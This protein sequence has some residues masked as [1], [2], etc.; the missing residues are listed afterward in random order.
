[1]NCS[2]GVRNTV[3]SSGHRCRDMFA[4]WNSNSKSRHGAQ[5]AHDDRQTVLAREI[6]GEA[7]VALDLDVRNIGQHPPREPDALLE[8]EHRR[9]A[10]VRRDGDDDAVEHAGGAAHQVLVAV[11]DR[12]ERAGI[13]GVARH[14]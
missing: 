2:C 6:D 1:M 14:A 5:A 9:L 7:G 4:S 13:A 8:R 12:I 3:S 11:G 10:G